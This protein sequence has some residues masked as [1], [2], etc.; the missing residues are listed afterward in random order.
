MAASHE[1]CL[2]GVK[3]WL[4]LRSKKYSVYTPSGDPRT[5]HFN[6]SF[7]NAALACQVTAAAFSTGGYQ[8]SETYLVGANSAEE[9]ARVEQTQIIVLIFKGVAQADEDQLWPKRQ[10]LWLS[11]DRPLESERG[12]LLELGM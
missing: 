12:E 5:K 2:G 8:N 4:A 10:N 9:M 1:L 11:T 3:S 6:G 7:P